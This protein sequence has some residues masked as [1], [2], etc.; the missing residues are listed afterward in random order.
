M[1]D[2]IFSRTGTDL[3]VGDATAT[4]PSDES[5][6]S[7]LYNN[8]FTSGGDYKEDGY[9]Y[10]GGKPVRK[11]FKRVE[12]I[13]VW[14]PI[15]E[16]VKGLQ[17]RYDAIRAAYKKYLEGVYKPAF[18]AVAKVKTAHAKVTHKYTGDDDPWWLYTFEKFSGSSGMS[19]DW[20]STPDKP[21]HLKV[22]QHYYDV[23][24]RLEQLGGRVYKFRTVLKRAIDDK[25]YKMEV[26]GDY[27]DLLKVTVLD[28]VYWYTRDQFV[29]GLFASD[30]KH[31]TV[32][33]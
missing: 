8:R 5:A 4:I 14:F 7:L 6:L 30:D 12:D 1:T 21:L 33:L 11:W 22:G 2:T 10:V 24:R 25:L 3:K 15:L 16:D 20:V 18:T 29:W 17:R 19:W 26:K 13:S 27:G 31:K 32:E 9:V 23:E 28:S